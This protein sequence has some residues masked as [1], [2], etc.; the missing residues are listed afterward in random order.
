MKLPY[1][2][3]YPQHNQKTVG[4][5]GGINERLVI[6]SHEFASMQ[7]MTD[8]HY[9]TICSRP[10]RGTEQRTFNKPHGLIWKNGIFFVDGTKCYYKGEE[11]EGLTVTDTD[12]QL[13]GMG[14]YVVIFPD[15]KVYNTHTGEVSSI[16]AEYVQTAPITFEELS[17]D[18]VFCKITAAGIDDVLHQYDGVKFEGVEDDTFILDGAGVTKVITEIGDD[19][20]VVTGAIQKSFMG[21]IT[22]SASGTGTRIAGDGIE[23]KFALGDTV[24]V[25]GVKDA[26]LCV[27]GQ[28]VTAVGEGYIDI[29]GSFPAKSYTQSATMTI[30]QYYSGSELVK[31]SADDLSIFS[32]GDVVQISGCTDSAL[33]GTHTIEQAGSNFILIK[34]AVA[35]T[36][37]QTTG[38]SIIRTSAVS[39]TATVTRTAFL[40]ESGITISREC[41]DMD[42]VCEHDNRLWGCS[43][44]NHEIYASKLGDPFN[45][46]VYE[47]TSTDSYTLSVGSDGDFTGCVSHLGYIIFFK[48]NTIHMMYG[49]KPSNF[50]L[51]S[52]QLP[53]VRTG[54]AA[55]L[56]VVGETLYYVGRNG[57]YSFDGAFPRKISEGIMSE[58]SDAVSGQKDGRL[59]ISCLKDGKQALLVYDPTYQLWDQEDDT[60][61]LFE[62]YADGELVYIGADNVMRN[63]Y[64]VQDEII[65]WE[66][67]SGWIDE[68]SLNQKWISKLKFNF[69]LEPYG[70]AL[71]YLQYNNGLM[72]EKVTTVIANDRDTYTLPIIPRRCTHLRFK[73]SGKRGFKLFGYGWYVEQGSEINGAV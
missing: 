12:K 47:G 10:A 3:R 16:T 46:N 19:Y 49:A 37:T 66:L 61:F 34:A 44:A 17:T 24:K 72:W 58:L 67:V 28:E 9:P 32:D 50:S 70:E 51:N 62:T 30:A 22:M 18:S 71:F 21:D 48:E 25:V 63:I 26:A 33:N 65:E 23:D 69:E 39:D 5:F 8:M 6:R 60:H 59:Y 38:I 68:S 40:R 56:E 1:I 2:Q 31:F 14:A 73:I 13:V 64:G 45:W 43:S 53:G 7:N 57:V 11:I 35:A 52:K 41:R 4:A 55:S 36:E 20:I 27:S 54:C 29:A 42:Y 15:K